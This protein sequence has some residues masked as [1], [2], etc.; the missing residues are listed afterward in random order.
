MQTVLPWRGKPRKAERRVT[1]DDLQRQIDELQRSRNTLAQQVG[2][3]ADPA[4]RRCV[5]IVGEALAR[6]HIRL[7]DAI[8]YHDRGEG[9][10]AARAI[11]RVD[12][13]LATAHAA[14]NE[15]RERN[16]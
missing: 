14:L 5:Q 12:Q 6:G 3:T 11:E 7:K 13:E 8:A 4:W 15:W 10:Y 1:I 9:E 16:G 2:G